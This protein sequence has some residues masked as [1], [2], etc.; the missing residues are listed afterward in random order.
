M[1]DGL[2]ADTVSGTVKHHHSILAEA[3]GTEEMTRC[4]ILAAYQ[5]LLS[6][7][8]LNHVNI[9]FGI[10]KE[11]AARVR[12]SGFNIRRNGRTRDVGKAELLEFIEREDF[13]FRFGETIHFT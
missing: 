11:S 7:H 6:S 5:E 9:T 4:N 3:P 8:E 13:N 12:L 10:L 1:E 2:I